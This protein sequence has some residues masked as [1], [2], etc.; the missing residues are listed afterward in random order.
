MVLFTSFFSS[1]PAHRTLVDL[2]PTI[3]ITKAHMKVWR[4]YQNSHTWDFYFDWKLTPAA[5]A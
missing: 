4:T 5:V 1:F 2:R 3:A